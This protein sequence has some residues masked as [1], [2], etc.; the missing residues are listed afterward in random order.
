MSVVV[1]WAGAYPMLR[2]AVKLLQRH[3]FGAPLLSDIQRERFGFC[4]RANAP[5][6]T[7]DRPVRDHP[8]ILLFPVDACAGVGWRHNSCLILLLWGW[9][10]LPEAWMGA[11][12]F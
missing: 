7:L 11:G 3:N 6:M 5:A 2:L 8:G 1:S 12:Q 9:A 10:H 4:V